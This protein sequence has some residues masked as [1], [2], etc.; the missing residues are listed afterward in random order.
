MMS[1]GQLVT[2]GTSPGVVVDSA[3]LD[4]PEDHVAVWYGEI[5]SDGRHRVRTVPECY[6]VPAKEQPGLSLSPFPRPTPYLVEL[7]FEGLIVVDESL[8]AR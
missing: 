2:V 4:V 5:A 8:L 1:P 7:I 3:N 6:V